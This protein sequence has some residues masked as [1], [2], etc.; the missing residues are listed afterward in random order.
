MRVGVVVYERFLRR[1][2]MS[3]L[4]IDTALQLVPLIRS[5]N[6][7]LCESLVLGQMGTLSPSP[8]DI[9]R[10]LS[11][12]NDP[13]DAARHFDD[14]FEAE[15]QRFKIGAAYTEMNGFDINPDR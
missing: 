15:S 10:N 9:A 3:D 1:G 2:F 4:F 13:G 12:T 14:F 7:E 6:L 8:F 11:I 5:G